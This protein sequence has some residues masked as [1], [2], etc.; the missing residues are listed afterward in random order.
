[1]LHGVQTT[2]FFAAN[3]QNNYILI[4]F[5]LFLLIHITFGPQFISTWYFIPIFRYYLFVF[6]SYLLFTS[7]SVHDNSVRGKST[8]WKKSSTAAR[9]TYDIWALSMYIMKQLNWHEYASNPT[10]ISQ[11]QL[12]ARWIIWFWIIFC[13]VLLFEW[14]AFWVTTA[15][16]KCDI[17]NSLRVNILCRLR[18]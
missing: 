4:L 5:F 14:S 2:D 16:S 13:F 8:V 1:M 9:Y 3:K 10:L 17:E 11:Y 18:C 7:S 15:G 6:S 12:C